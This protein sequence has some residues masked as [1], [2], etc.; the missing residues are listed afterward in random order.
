MLDLSCTLLC[1][2]AYLSFD[3]ASTV[4]FLKDGDCWLDW[5]PVY[6]PLSGLG[7]RTTLTVMLY[8]NTHTHTHTH[9]TFF[10]SSTVTTRKMGG[11]IAI[12]ECSSHSATQSLSTQPYFGWG[13]NSMLHHIAMTLHSKHGAYQSWVQTPVQ[14]FSTLSNT[15]INS[16]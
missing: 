12:I 1:W 14:W 9:V 7:T 16:A 8:P 5:A 4:I 15:C 2:A 10:D 3:G 13:D 11:S 6:K